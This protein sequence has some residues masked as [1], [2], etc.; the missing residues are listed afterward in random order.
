MATIRKEFE[1]GPGTPRPR[2]HMRTFSAPARARVSV[3]IEQMEVDPDSEQVPVS[4]EVRR[5]SADSIGSTGPD[6]PRAADPEPALAPRGFFSPF[7]NRSFVSNFG[8]PSTWRVRVRAL[9][10]DVPARVS[11]RILVVTDPADAVHLK[12]NGSDTQ[13]L[14]P[15]VVAERTLE[16]A[17]SGRIVGTGRFRIK[18]KWHTEQP[19]VPHQQLTVALL[20]PDG[21]LATDQKGFS[22]HS[23]I[24]DDEDEE[25]S[26]IDFTYRV[27]PQDIAL[28][29]DWKLRIANN[30]THRVVDFDIRKGSDLNPFVQSF[31]STFLARCD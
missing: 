13:D 17:D 21:L 10:S 18:A 26:V 14:D 5:A 7:G 31:T 30:S 12:M 6:G 23:G 3:A 24:E 27:T 11:G 4:I 9:N 28:S 19:F 1:F 8:C 25:T 29:G 22:Q 15:N 16:P 2:S 20:K